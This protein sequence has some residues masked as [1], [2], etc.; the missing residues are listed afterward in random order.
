MESRD[1]SS[2]VKWRGGNHTIFPCCLLT[3]VRF[4]YLSE[5]QTQREL[6]GVRRERQSNQTEQSSLHSFT[7]QMATTA[8][9]EP[10]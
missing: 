3:K 10:G 5:N 4:I 9:A 1:N 7:P 8:S 6:Q 2:E